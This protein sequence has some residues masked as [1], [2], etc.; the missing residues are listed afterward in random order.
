MFTERMESKQEI[1]VGGLDADVIGFTS[2]AV[3]LAVD[4]LATRGGG[5]VRLQAGT[6]DVAAPIR[7]CSRIE[8]V[9]CGEKTVLRKIP[10][11]ASRLIVDPGYGQLWVEVEEEHEFLPGMGLLIQDTRNPYGWD[12]CTAVITAIESNRLYLDRRLTNNFDTDYEATASN[13]CSIVEAVGASHVIVRDLTIEGAKETNKS[14]G[15]CRGGGVYLYEVTDA[16]ISRVTVRGFNGDGISWQITERIRVEHCEVNG[17]TGSG[18]HP[19]ARSVH[20]EID[21]CSSHANGEDGLFVCWMVQQGVFS[22]N[23]FE[24][25]E[26][27]G[28]S[29]GH[30]DTDNLFQNNLIRCNGVHGIY[31]RPEKEMNGA[32]RNRFVN[33][34]VEDNGEG[35]GAGVYLEGVTR[36]WH[37]TRNRIRNTTGQQRQR[38]AI[39]VKENAEVIEED[40][41]LQGD[42]IRIKK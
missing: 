11:I 7:L 31:A 17:C 26:R 16:L 4:A 32:H 38:Y 42:Y 29:I 39:V 1:T 21:S 34:T 36:D 5:T 8:L 41:V 18:L 9:G 27:H 37:L 20:T 22:G 3:Q 35:E 30:Q 13:A 14:I 10:G 25:N 40:N 28:I 15:G 6:F 24:S 33:N 19:G 2:Q 23:R 12:E